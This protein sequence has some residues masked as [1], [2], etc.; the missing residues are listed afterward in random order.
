V[1][2]DV[3]SSDAAVSVPARSH[4][5]R[6]LVLI[7]VAGFQFWMWGTRLWNMVQDAGD[8]SAAFVG[9]HVAL[10]SIG[11]LTGG[12]LAVLGGRMVRESRSRGAG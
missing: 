7:V 6:G 2:L 4:R 10:F 3:T 8:A 5:R 1:A 12:V 11:I 9:V